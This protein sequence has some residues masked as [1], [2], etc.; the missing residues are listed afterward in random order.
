MGSLMFGA[1]LGLG[2]KVDLVQEILVVKLLICSSHNEYNIA[3]GNCI[4]ILK[5]CLYVASMFSAL[6]CLSYCK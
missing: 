6:S 1:P 4:L 3:G 2:C 5:S